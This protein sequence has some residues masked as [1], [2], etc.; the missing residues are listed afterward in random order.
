MINPGQLTSI[1]LDIEQTDPQLFAQLIGLKERIEQNEFVAACLRSEAVILER[2]AREVRE[3]ARASVL[4]KR[5][6]K[7][8]LDV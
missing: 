5:N 7:N 2:K 1:A 6:H 4:G 8:P 3:S